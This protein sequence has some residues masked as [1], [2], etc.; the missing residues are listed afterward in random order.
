[1]NES[2]EAERRGGGQDKDREEIRVSG[3]EDGWEFDSRWLTN[4][5][6]VLF[7]SHTLPLSYLGNEQTPLSSFLTQ[8]NPARSY[9]L[10]TQTTLVW[11]VTDAYI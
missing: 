8:Q 1:M 4:Y 7:T 2:R 6:T 10:S 9:P 5:S 3:E 11:N